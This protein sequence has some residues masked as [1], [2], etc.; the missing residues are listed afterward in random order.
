MD[1]GPPMGPER[2]QWELART[3]EDG[4]LL[5][6]TDGKWYR[7]QI[8]PDGSTRVT[9]GL[10]PFEATDCKECKEKQRLEKLRLEQQR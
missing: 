8:M 3:L 7:K 5:R 1:D 2:I 6:E 10:L 4:S 9:K